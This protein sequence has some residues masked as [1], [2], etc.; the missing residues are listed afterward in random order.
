MGEEL[1]VYMKEGIFPEGSM[2]PKLE[3]KINAIISA[4]LNK[5]QNNILFWIF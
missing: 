2:A 4:Y 5:L 3:G 1:L